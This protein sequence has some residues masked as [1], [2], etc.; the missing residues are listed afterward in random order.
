VLKAEPDNLTAGNN[1]AWL[2]QMKKDSR[3][4]PLAEALHRRAPRDANVSDTL[5]WILL[6]NGEGGRALALLEGVAATPAAP[7]DARYHLALALKSQGRLDDA[8]R[9][10]EALLGEG[11]PFDSMAESKA[12]MKELA[13]G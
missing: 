10:L 11:K 2:Y 4:L 9:T 6:Q 7:L 3:A 5:G 8:R 1:L 12:L 13:G